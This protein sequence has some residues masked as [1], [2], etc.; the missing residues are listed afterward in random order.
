WWVD[1]PVLFPRGLRGDA[2]RLEQILV[3]LLGNAIKFTD[4][5]GE[6]V[7]GVAVARE[8]SR[9]TVL[10]FWVRDTGIGMTPEQTARLFQPF[11]QGDGS[12]TRQY[13]GTGLGL[14]ISRRLAEQMGGWIRV[15]SA[16]GIGSEFILEVRLEREPEVSGESP[17]CAPERTL[18][19]KRVLILSTRPA[20]R[21]ILVRMAGDLGLNTMVFA[22]PAAALEAAE[23]DFFEL[24]ILDAA[25]GELTGLVA[26]FRQRSPGARIVALVPMDLREGVRVA[27]VDEW[28]VRP[29]LPDGLRA[30]CTGIHGEVQALSD[31]GVALE[32]GFAGARVLLVEDNRIN[33]MV[34]REILTGFG[35]EVVCVDNGLE[36]VERVGKERFAG[37]LM[38]LQ[39]PVMD[40]LTATR[41][42]RMLEGC[43]DLP[44]LA[45]TAQAMPGDR[46]RCLEVGMTDYV[47]KPIDRRQLRKVLHQWI[48]PLETRP[49]PVDVVLPTHSSEAVP[50]R[51]VL[52]EKMAGIDLEEAM[53]R[54]DGNRQLLRELLE[55][56]RRDHAGDARRVRLLLEDPERLDPDAAGKLL[57][58][59]KGLAGNLGAVVIRENALELERL[60][61][62]GG[63]PSREALE[64]FEENF[65]ELLDAVA[66]L[67]PYAGEVE[68][69]DGEYPTVELSLERLNP[70]F[71]ALD[72]RLVRNDLDAERCLADLKVALRGAGGECAAGVQ[73]IVSHMDRYD[74]D[75][76]RNALHQLVRHLSREAIF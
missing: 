54:L 45:M 1:P 10:R 66:A 43:G 57:H 8:E 28:L 16:A 34:A 41:R 69:P 49:A 56:F 51:E 21:R 74:F 62:G 55:V 24:V 26:D 25:M 27:G 61:K 14:A 39:M 68:E 44:I 72:E 33:Q 5:G 32:R 19:G 73:A 40:G 50:L 2:M 17:T 76:A 6:V 36:A 35:L 12:I 38:D 70:L 3:N 37:V 63:L 47:A 30:V 65:Q 48:R 18:A 20:G 53:E 29:V 4:P 59:I 13:G 75:G 7:L 23:G 67:P 64:R 31:Q 58:A 52:P 15:A 22:V 9:A 11:S 60:L 71:A 46:E 42:I